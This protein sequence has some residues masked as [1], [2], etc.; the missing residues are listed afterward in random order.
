M[1]FMLIMKGKNSNILNGGF[2][3][4]Y[5]EPFGKVFHMPVGMLVL[6]HLL[7]FTGSDSLQDIKQC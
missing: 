5:S 6:W 2:L 1:M 4:D 3:N 7:R